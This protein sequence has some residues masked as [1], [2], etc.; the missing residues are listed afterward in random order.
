M[1]DEF[2]GRSV[3][4][5]EEKHLTGESFSNAD[6]SSFKVDEKAK[7]IYGYDDDDRK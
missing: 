2:F 1:F 5:S 4:P 6:P 3:A 7:D